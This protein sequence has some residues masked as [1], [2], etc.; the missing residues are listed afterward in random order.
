[1][2]SN[3]GTGGATSKPTSCRTHTGTAGIPTTV[4]TPH[5][6]YRPARPNRSAP[7]LQAPH[8]CHALPAG[9]RWENPAMMRVVQ[10][11]P[12]VHWVI[13]W[14][15]LHASRVTEKV[16]LAW[17]AVIHDILPTSERL[18]AITLTDIDGCRQCGETDTLTHWFTGC[19]EGP[20]IW[21]W[22]KQR[23]AMM[24][25]ME[26]NCM[27]ISWLLHPDFRLWPPPPPAT[28]SRTVN[29]SP[30]GLVS[31]T[32]TTTPNHGRLFRLHAALQMEGIRSP[33]TS[34]WRWQLLVFELAVRRLLHL[35]W[36]DPPPFTRGSD[37]PPSRQ[38]PVTTHS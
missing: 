2:A 1:M 11:R 5:G 31:N 13:V 29:T 9:D 34:G 14:W 21:N 10:K 38:P 20:A 19:G 33:K 30:L 23:I 15:N 6:L 32:R 16:R 17:Y 26:P 3:L 28:T 36:I 22:T 8:I 18:A 12:T 27:P 37:L 25:R 4:R 7:K 24:L 35:T